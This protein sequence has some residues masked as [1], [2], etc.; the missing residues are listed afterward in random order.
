MIATIYTASWGP[1]ERGR[2]E[3]RMDFS[4]GR[5][6]NGKFY[7]T[8]RVRPVFVEEPNEILVMTAYVYYF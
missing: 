1:A 3:C 7:A 6:W 5:E 2:C 8:K 4:Y